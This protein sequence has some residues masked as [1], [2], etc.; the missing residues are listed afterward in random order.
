MYLDDELKGSLKRVR[1]AL[2][3]ELLDRAD[4][5]PWAQW[6]RDHPYEPDEGEIA[7]LEY[8]EKWHPRPRWR[9]RGWH[10]LTW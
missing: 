4:E 2:Y 5:M 3:D 10:G 1:K 7:K 8:E 9:P 6:V